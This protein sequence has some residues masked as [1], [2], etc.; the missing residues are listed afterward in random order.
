VPCRQ[1]NRKHC[2]EGRKNITAP[3]AINH[4]RANDEQ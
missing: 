2:A 4:H 1:E 3:T